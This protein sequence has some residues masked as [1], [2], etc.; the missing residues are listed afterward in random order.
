MDVDKVGD[1]D[2]VVLEEEEDDCNGD[3]NVVGVEHRT[4]ENV[5]A[6]DVEETKGWESLLPD[7]PTALDVSAAQ[8]LVLQNA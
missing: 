3:S 4:V 6:A 2:K 7:T 1:N 5:A 8:A